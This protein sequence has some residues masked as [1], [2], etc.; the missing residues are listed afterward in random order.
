MKK[1]LYLIDASGFIWR[2]FHALPPLTNPQ[3]TPVGAVMGFCNMLLKLVAEVDGAPVGVIFDS[4]RITFR[5]TIYPDYKA[6]RGETPEDLI[7]QFP[8]V[9]AAVDA[10]GLAA[11]EAEG[12]EA[13]DLLATYAHQAIAQNIADEVILVSSD[14]DLMQLVNDRVTML[15]PMKF[16]RIGH[17][18]VIEKFGVAPNRVV[19]VQALA[20]DS[21]DNVPG[22][23]GIGVKT[24]AQLINEYGDLETLLAR[25]DEIKQPK[26][27]ERLVNGA[28]DA[29]V[30]AELVK[31]RSDAP[32]PVALTELRPFLPRAELLS[33]VQLQG[34]QR[35]AGRLQKS[36]QFDGQPVPPVVLA[37][38]DIGLRQDNDEEHVDDWRAAASARITRLTSEM[39]TVET[40]YK[41]IRSLQELEPYLAKAHETGVLAIDTETNSLTPARADWVG[42]SLCAEVGQACYIPLGHYP[43][44]EQGTRDLLGDAEEEDTSSTFE[45]EVVENLDL[46]DV[47]D[48]LKPVLIDP[49]VR[50]IGH[51]LAYDLQ[52][53]LRDDITVMPIE[54]TIVLSYSLDA[55]ARRHSLDA[56]CLDLFG[57]ELISYDVLTGTG[58]NRVTLADLDARAVSDYAAE[59]ADMALR[60]YHVLSARLVAE[61]KTA[62]Y[63][64]YDLP[65][66]PILA[67]M[68][69]R[70]IC[71]DAM[72]LTQLSDQFTRQAQDL[73]QEIYKQA[74]R[75]FNIGSPKQVG[76]ILFD[77]LGLEAK[78][79]KK[80][81]TGAWST[82]AK[83]LEE[84][85]A[86]GYD[87][88]EKILS[89]RQLT[90][91][92]STYTVAL[93]EQIVPRTGRLHTHFSQTVTSTGRLS[94]SDP[95]LQNI[96]IR[97]E[98]G[99][100]IRKA[101]VPAEGFT[102]IC[103]DYSQVE[104]RLIAEMA[105]I[106]RLKK[107]FI[108]GIDIHTLT[109]SEVFGIPIDAMTP[110]KRRAAKA[111]NFGIIYGISG[112]GLGRQLG[113]ETSVAGEYIKAYM[114]RFPE[115]ADYMEET[116]EFARKNGYVLT[117]AGR[118]ITIDGA[119]AKGPQRGFAERQAIN[120]PIQG[121]AADIMKAA[122]IAVDKKLRQNRD[123]GARLLLQVHD[124]LVI[125][126]PTK[127]AETVATA[128]EEAMGSVAPDLNIPLEVGVGMGNNWQ[129]AH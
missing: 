6:N 83:T 117:R 17:D 87:I 121:T 101:F 124:E 128:V 9:R 34:F 95:N 54:D 99:R 18:E 98:D 48:V 81:K 91:L 4:G 19:D 70:G 72:R 116:K 41:L 43:K 12:F 50:K 108:D 68:S 52:M 104:L 14:K 37:A 26:R 31:L 97:T 32:M 88:V 60:L 45:G 89:W 33:F 109:A 23:A 75:D 106:K 1:P 3:G 61:R 111:I 129:E 102:L 96:P 10:F 78:G 120:A 38:G 25:A 27:R 77:E 8:L 82:S 35:L 15:D 85:A 127:H 118:K 74:G 2:A 28:E 36:F 21:T 103:A 86:Q 58:K 90:K 112:Y 55:G 62:I 42:I 94:S 44:A 73:A 107:A 16:R 110:E 29:R 79:A 11:I 93:Q 39:T 71:V 59:D 65:L 76:E 125:E 66:V 5:Q 63:R 57:H 69:T 13:D 115:L 100:R 51:N 7:P 67:E 114:A 56:L 92:T 20:G 24:A 105:D 84:L 113:V 47:F 49:T 64:Q 119:N 122:M 30:S 126:A 123:W 22:I 40:E 46:A 80:T 53:F